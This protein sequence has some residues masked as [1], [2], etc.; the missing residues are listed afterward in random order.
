MWRTLVMGVIK[1]GLGCEFDRLHELVNEHK[2]LRRFLGYADV[3]E[4]LRYSYQRLVDNVSLLRPELPGEIN[5]LIVGSGHA[6]LG[7]CLAR[8]W[9]AL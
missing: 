4:D 3:W 9:R 7:K 6:V 2:T 1:Q 5:H 8:P